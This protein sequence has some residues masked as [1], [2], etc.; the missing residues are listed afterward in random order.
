MVRGNSFTMR[1][2]A[3]IDS[4]IEDHLS[5][6]AT[7]ELFIPGLDEVKVG[8]DGKKDGNIFDIDNYDPD[9]TSPTRVKNFK[10]LHE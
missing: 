6:N 5:K 1:L 10:A 2:S 3:R 9:I 7:R 4:L 8:K